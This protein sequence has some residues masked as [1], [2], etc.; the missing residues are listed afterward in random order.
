MY[1]Y[2]RTKFKV[3]SVILTSF[4]QG[5]NIGSMKLWGTLFHNNHIDSYLKVLVIEQITKGWLSRHFSVNGH[6]LCYV[7]RFFLFFYSPF[8][9][10]PF[11][12]VR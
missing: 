9:Q 11:A 12:I 2:L 6:L 4:R 10:A 1:L 5:N 3:S 8:L 7:N